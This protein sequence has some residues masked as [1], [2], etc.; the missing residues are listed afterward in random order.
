MSTFLHTN[1]CYYPS[2]LQ[3]HQRYQ[4]VHSLLHHTLLDSAQIHTFHTKAIHFSSKIAR[5]TSSGLLP[6]NAIVNLRVHNLI[7]SFN[8]SFQFWWREIQA[9]VCGEFVKT[10]V[11]ELDDIVAFVTEH[12][13]LP[14]VPQ[15]RNCTSPII[16]T[17]SRFVHFLQ[18][19]TPVNLIQTGDKFILILD[20]DIVIL[21]LPRTVLTR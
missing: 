2:D 12:I 4:K 3:S 21:E 11:E 19:P 18:I 16:T 13:F 17:G 20:R 7:P 6:V 1:I 14:R 15:H 5:S 10:R 8:L 9:R